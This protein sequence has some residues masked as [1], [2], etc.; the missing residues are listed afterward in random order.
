MPGYLSAP[1]GFQ[2]FQKRF[3]GGE[4]GGVRLRRRRAFRFAV[5]AFRVGENSLDE[6]RRSRNRFADAI[7]FN[8]VYSDGNYHKS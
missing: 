2:R 3:F 5:G 1:A 7:N 4:A 8:N 6:T